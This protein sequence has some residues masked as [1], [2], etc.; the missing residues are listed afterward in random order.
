MDEQILP[1]EE[2][3]QE[4]EP[5]TQ[6]PVAESQE[7]P[8]WEIPAEEAPAEEA[9]KAKFPI[10]TLAIIG[11]AVVAIA[12]VLIILLAP[13]H[14]EKVR[15]EAVQRAGQIT[16]AGDHGFTIDTKPYENSNNAYMNAWS[17]E[18]ALEGIQY[19]NKELGFS[20]NLYSRMLNTTA[21]MGVQSEENS[22][23]LVTWTYHPQKGLEVTYYEK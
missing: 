20:S 8:T 2:I 16:H 4:Q 22:K 15:D 13:S 21:L 5:A 17:Q 23:Y 1:T 18:K 9:P 10:K 7:Q 11:V 19:V 3:T 12:I 14:F 6:E